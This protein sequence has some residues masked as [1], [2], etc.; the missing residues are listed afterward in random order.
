[1]HVAHREMTPLMEPFHAFVRRSATDGLALVAL[2][3][4]A[5]G[6]VGLQPP[7]GFHS[8]SQAAIG[9]G[10]G[11]SAESP[12]KSSALPVGVPY[13]PYSD[14][15]NFP[16]MSDEGD[17]D[18]DIFPS[19]EYQDPEDVATQGLD[20][21]TTMDGFDLASKIN[22]SSWS[23]HVGSD[24]RG[25]ACAPHMIFTGHKHMN[26][27]HT[28]SRPSLGPQYME[29][30]SNRLLVVPKLKFAFCY[31]EKNAC[32]QFNTL[33]N[34]LNRYEYSG[35]AVFLKSSYQTFNMDSEEINKAN[36]WRMAVFLRDPSERFLSAWMS[37]CVAWE[38]KG[39]NC[40]GGR[41]VSGNDSNS[42]ISSFETM[43]DRDLPA[44]VYLR[45]HRWGG[46]YNSHYDP[47][48]N[49]CN[50]L[51]LADFDYVGHLVGNPDVVHDQVQKMLRDVAM[52][53]ENEMES[54]GVESIF[55][56]D[57]VEG[58][59]SAYFGFNDT[60]AMLNSFYAS[61]LVREAVSEAFRSDY[62]LTYRGE[63]VFSSSW[64]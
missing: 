44:Y 60:S 46:A 16:S 24:E 7:L 59:H 42:G 37:K 20:V 21:R 4:Q 12:E 40:L 61:P 55:P 5:S 50:G 38:D 63:P 62:D 39:A 52:V 11:R 34:R 10:S 14:D 64:R 47:Q 45:D 19:T 29:Q 13:G 33:M 15:V 30:W 17:D 27:K 31:I 26:P 41:R 25:P 2:F 54:A 51:N 43:V 58:H 53:P 35:N 49:F 6:V 28:C 1:V 32:T 22:Y 23:E 36:G 3:L 9:S 18:D 48:A 8:G 57:Q 56:R